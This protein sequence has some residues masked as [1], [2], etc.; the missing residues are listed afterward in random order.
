MTDARIA[1]ALGFGALLAFQSLSVAAE[2]APRVNVRDLD[3]NSNTGVEIALE[4]V[5]S[6]AIG[7]CQSPHVNA[8]DLGR[9]RAAERCV[10]ATM[11]QTV[12]QLRAPLVSKL[13]DNTSRTAAKKA[14]ADIALRE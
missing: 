12:R 13:Y 3:L 5:K 11:A 4:R 1:V 14:S 9:S 2:P 6:A 7:I 10:E 8:A